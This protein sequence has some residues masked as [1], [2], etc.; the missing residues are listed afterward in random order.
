MGRAGPSAGRAGE[1][2]GREDRGAGPGGPE[3]RAGKIEGSG[4]EDRGAVRP[5]A[6]EGSE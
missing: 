3:G 2:A 5:A 4:R 6:A 1:G